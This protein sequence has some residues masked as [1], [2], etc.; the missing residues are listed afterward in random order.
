MTL[1]FRNA[2][3]FRDYPFR[4]N[5]SGDNIASKFVK[6]AIVDAQFDVYSDRLA[7]EGETP[8][9]VYVK[10]IVYNGSSLGVEVETGF[11]LR[12]IDDSPKWGGNSDIPRERMSLTVSTGVLAGNYVYLWLSTS[13]SA[14]WFFD[15]YEGYEGS[16]G[17][18]TGYI[19]LDTEYLNSAPT[20]SE[21]FAPD[22]IG[23]HTPILEDG[24]VTFTGTQ[25]TRAI[26]IFNLD[27]VMIGNINEEGDPPQLG[28]LIREIR[29][30]GSGN[31]D[32]TFGNVTFTEGFNCQI[33]TDPKNS[34]LTITAS[35]GKG[36]G[37]VCESSTTVLTDEG[38]EEDDLLPLEMCTDFIYAINGINPQSG[39]MRFRAIPPFQ[40]SQGDPTFTSEAR[41][42][43]TDEVDP[44]INDY[45]RGE[46]FP[47]AS[48]GGPYNET[49]LSESDFWSHSL[50]FKM[51][52][53][54]EQDGTGCDTSCP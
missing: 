53:W 3:E 4:Q 29:P 27:P 50:V 26:R 13:N 21:E 48:P 1:E 15:A 7:D 9:I 40:I 30:I 35:L 16:H 34:T 49:I 14:E 25:L 43:D 6:S 51:G 18:M 36:A 24:C 8:P 54:A 10:N 37:E 20:V 45:I 38:E 23:I 32:V 22:S 44:D 31:S 2:N 12:N 28:T 42:P 46:N 19:V 5:P 47:V 17:Y 41:D 39:D 11:G 33:Q 52:G